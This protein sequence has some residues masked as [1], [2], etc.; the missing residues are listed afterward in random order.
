MTSKLLGRRNLRTT[1]RYR[2][3]EPVIAW[4]EQARAPQTD[5]LGGISGGPALNAAGEIVG[6]TI[7]SSRRRGRV[8]TTAPISMDSMLK[9]ADARAR[10]RPS[11]GLG[12]PSPDGY[13]EYGVALRRQLTVAMVVCRV[14]K[15][16]R[17]RL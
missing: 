17:R 3:T 15:K 6:V 8:Y 4:A 9:L 16:R 14:G 1:G 10:G 2:Q 7:A 13:V 5:T 12:A 11:A